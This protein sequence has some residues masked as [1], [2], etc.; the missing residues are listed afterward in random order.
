MIVEKAFAKY[1]GCYDRMAASTVTQGLEDLTGGIGY[2][3][4]LEKPK[5]ADWILPK[6]SIP[7]KL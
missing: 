6:G 2:K 1:L 5:Y 7:E 3:F 4:D